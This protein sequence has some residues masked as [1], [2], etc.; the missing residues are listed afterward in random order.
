MTGGDQVG[1]PEH[2]SSVAPGVWRIRVPLPGSPLRNLNSWVVTSDGQALVIDT[3]FNMPECLDAMKSGLAAIG[4]NPSRTSFMLT[5][6][7]S[8]HTGLV[9]RLAAPGT[10]IFMGRLDAPFMDPG[11]NWWNPMVDYAVQNGFGRQQISDALASH[12][13]IK[14]HPGAI[15]PMKLLED[16]DSITVGDRELACVL[17]P[18]HTPG[19][20]CL[21]D[22]QAR[23]LFSGDHV[24]GD[25]TPHIESWA[26]RFNALKCFMSSLEKIRGLDVVQALPG[27]RGTIA[28]LGPRIDQL[29]AHHAAR[30]D[31]TVQ[32]LGG[33]CMTAYEIAS[34]MTWDVRAPSWEQFPITQKWFAVGETIAHLRWL[35]DSG[36][37]RRQIEDGIARFCVGE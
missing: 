4:A 9:G 33:G 18:G 5:H 12:P 23:L 15:G 10:D 28:E 22:R 6:M 36:R 37:V 7:H 16:G 17:T 8:D 1:L 32:V 27:H 29:V 2:V 20:I 34:R 25:I 30:A 13:G 19:H 14:F 26:Y 24:L 3:G 35:E 31:E 11:M 21:Y